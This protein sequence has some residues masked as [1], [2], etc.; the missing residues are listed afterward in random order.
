MKQVVVSIRDRAAQCFSRP[1]FTQTEGTAIRSFIDELN[2]DEAGNDLFKHPD[3]YD[4]YVIAIFDDDNGS[5]T[6]EQQPRLLLKGI[7]AK[8]EAT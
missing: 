6:L 2:R 4:L 3:D 1:V 5:F 7:Q 8:K